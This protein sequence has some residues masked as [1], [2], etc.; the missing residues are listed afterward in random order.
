MIRDIFKK[1]DLILAI[2]DSNDHKINVKDLSE[3]EI[4]D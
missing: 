2:N 1:L 4:N 3:I